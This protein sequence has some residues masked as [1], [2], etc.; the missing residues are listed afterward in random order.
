MALAVPVQPPGVRPPGAGAGAVTMTPAGRAGCSSGGGGGG[1]A[2]GG[3]GRRRCGE[4]WGRG[5]A[6][7]VEVVPQLFSDG[8]RAGRARLETQAR[9]GR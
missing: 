5:S 4:R 7:E 3:G 6:A 1:G 9:R 8:L 2:A